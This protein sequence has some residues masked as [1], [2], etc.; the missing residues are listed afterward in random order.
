MARKSIAATL[1]PLEN[2]TAKVLV[3]RGHR[4]LVDADLAELYG[5]PTKQLNQQVKRNQARFPED[6]MFQLTAVEKEE[7]VTICDHLSNL[8]FSRT[9]PYVFTEHGAIQ[10]ANVLNSRQAIETG[11]Q[12][13]RAF[14]RLRKMLISNTELARKLAALE[15]KYDAEFKVVF[16]AIRDL[17]A[18]PEP[19]KKRPIG[20]APWE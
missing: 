2:I 7:V 10:A 3:I 9:P 16:A 18:P 15:K 6:F 1:P 5:V 13:V 19:K 8:K 20:F 17:M 4:V 11:V 14:V 12:V